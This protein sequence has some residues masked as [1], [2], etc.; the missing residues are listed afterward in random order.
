M[1]TCAPIVPWP[2]KW[3]SICRSSISSVGHLL[4]ASFKFPTPPKRGAGLSGAWSEQSRWDGSF[5]WTTCSPG[6]P[7]RSGWLIPLWSRLVG[8]R[9]S[10]VSG[11][12]ALSLS[13]ASRAVWSS[14]WLGQL[15]AVG[16]PMW[17]RPVGSPRW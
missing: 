14:P 7:L 6:F 4:L 16:H 5:P 12:R 17:P 11:F 10:C 3:M 13:I 15:D 1:A 9:V 8:G 2:Q